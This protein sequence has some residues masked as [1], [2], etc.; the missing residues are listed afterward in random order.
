M[1]YTLNIYADGALVNTITSD[2]ENHATRELAKIFISKEKRGTKTRLRFIPYSDKVKIWQYF[3]KE[4][5][6]TTT[7]HTYEYIFEGVTL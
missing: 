4:T 1:K 6:G 7:S 3:P 5:C 2:D